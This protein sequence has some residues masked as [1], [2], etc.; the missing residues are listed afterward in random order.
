[1]KIPMPDFQ[2]RLLELY[3]ED[4]ARDMPF[5]LWKMQ[6]MTGEGEAFFLPEHGCYYVIRDKQLLFYHS[7][8]GDCHISVNELNQ[9]DC[10][11]MRSCFFDAIKERLVG[12]NISYG[13]SLFYD[14]SIAMKQAEPNRYEAVDFGF[15]NESNFQAAADIMNGDA[16]GG[17]TSH[18]LRRWTTL[19]PFDPNL[20]FFVRDK[21]LGTDVGV[22][23]STYHKDVKETD[24]DWVFIRPSYQ[25]KGAGRFMMEEVVR[26]S[27]NRSNVIRVGVGGVEAFYKRC[28][29][30][31]RECWGWA[32]RPGFRMNEQ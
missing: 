26:R 23:I 5:A 32:V 22:C 25:G 4:A 3:A 20:W 8:D 24:I 21:E 14:V 13:W 15:T 12:F 28:G 7:P 31:E 18:R 29:F 19:P 10:I 11:C 30:R 27:L 2:Q 1:M 16:D 17:Y 9:L 6:K